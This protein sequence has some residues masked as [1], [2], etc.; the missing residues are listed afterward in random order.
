MDA[1]KVDLVMRYALALAAREDQPFARRL[2]A[3]HLIKYVYVAD[4]AFAQRNNG[5]TFTG[6]DWTFYHFGPW[7]QP[8]FE[9]I[10]HVVHEIA[11]VEHWFASKY[12]KDSVRWALPDDDHAEEILAKADR[13]LPVEVASALKRAIRTIGN[14]TPALLHAVYLTP[15][16]LRA[17]PRERLSFENLPPLPQKPSEEKPFTPTA[18]QLKKQKEALR[19][20][21]EKIRSIPRRSSRTAPVPPPPY[22]EVFEEG[23]RWLDE[24]AAVPE[25]KGEVHFSDDFWKD[26]WRE[27][28][29]S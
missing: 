6:A 20:L 21:Q 14:D 1:S 19:A 27:P 3:I 23:V 15:P 25:L 22:D 11:A 10:P 7:S 16:M 2:G 12:D 17:A 26:P 9:R 29:D 4:L 5:Q 28:D 13:E 8:V 18:K 24:E